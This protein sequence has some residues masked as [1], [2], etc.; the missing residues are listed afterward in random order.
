MW[1]LEKGNFQNGRTEEPEGSPD[2]RGS[3]VQTGPKGCIFLSPNTEKFQEV[4]EIPLGREPVR[5]VV[6]MIQ[7]G[8]SPL[9]VYQINES[10]NNPTPTDKT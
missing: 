9:T 2:S 6:P 8:S 7:S 5:V 3:N 4:C 1:I 10:T